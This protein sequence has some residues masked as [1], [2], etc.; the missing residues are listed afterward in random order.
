VQTLI[1]QAVQDVIDLVGSGPI[2]TRLYRNAEMLATLGGAMLTELSYFP[3]Q[4]SRNMSAYTQYADQ[5]KMRSQRLLQLFTAD[6]VDVPGFENM[7]PAGSFSG[8][9][10]PTAWW[11]Q[12]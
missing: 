2:P 11:T 10:L 3:E 4:I 9:I 5:Y 7:L 6:D 8:Q 1:D 12:W